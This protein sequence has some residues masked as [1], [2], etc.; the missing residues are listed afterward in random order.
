MIFYDT[1]RM[2]QQV[3]YPSLS[4]NVPNDLCLTWKNISYT[5]ERKTNGGSLR[6][7]FGFQYSEL[8]QLL[9]GVS[10]IVNSGMLMAIMGPSG[11]GKTTLLATI[12]RRVK[13]K[14]TGDVL[15]NGKPID[16]EQMIRISGFVPQTDLAIE[17]L[18]IQEHMEFMA[19]MKMDRRLRA[20]FRRQRI[21][22]LLREL[23][24]AKCTSTKLSALS[25]GERKRV[26]LAV[27]LLTEPSILFCDEPTTGLDSYGAM[28]VV[29]T[30]REVAASGRIV[31]CSLHQPASGLLE[32][33]HE[34]LLLS[35]G[36][37]AFQGSS[38][39]ATEFFDSLNLPC[40]P[41]FNSAE[42]YVSQLSIIRDKEAESYRK[43][44][45]I[46]DQY[47]KSKYG[48]RVS[49]LIE[50]FCV[51]ESMKL[52]S[53][54][55]DVSL[56]LKNFKKARL[57]TQLHW[58][59]WRIYL[60]YKRNYTTL[61]LR[62]ITYMCIGV[63]IGLP[64][65]NIS[66]QAMN[67]DTI[68]NMQGL[69][70]LVV[71]ETVFTFNYAVFY[72]FPRELPLLLRDIASGLYGPAPYYISKVIVLIPGAIIQPLLYS[73]FI[74]AITGLKGGLLGFVY[75]ALPV[76]VCAISASAFASFKSMETA[77]LFSVPLDFLGL[78]FC[79]IYLHLGNLAPGIAWLKYL[80]QF[81]YGLEAVSLTQWL[82]IDHINC[83]SDPEEPCISSGLE[84]LEKYGYL[85]IHYTMDI[86][87]LLVIFS[88][89]HL[90]GFLVI[91]HRS[92]K[93]P[94]Y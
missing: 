26:T 35:S 79:G 23:G 28:T 49:K 90:A 22:V 68:Q 47:E 58:L 44:N 19:C 77:S 14:A 8:I 10:G 50:Y 69:L 39:D 13:G 84:V 62:F 7:I 32:I 12:S 54:F 56:S 11:A 33:F 36:R 82:L 80:S 67:Q 75:F 60:D 16:T 85:P 43:V 51:T 53:I 66:R 86:I 74:F 71:V 30:L 46:C 55:S 1:I 89:S 81:Y 41:T 88:F 20:N 61:F 78:M 45:W 92:R 2:K 59:V 65:M 83:S 64:F 94:V 72:T 5:V 42:F 76:V 21:T 52:P 15:L 37:V 70:Y 6:A 73:A 3:K 93:E 27:E 31:I 48:L 24:L 87:G 91:R 18:T 4:L 34:V 57:L 9:H 40:P 38:I 29:R 25:G 63:L 17:S